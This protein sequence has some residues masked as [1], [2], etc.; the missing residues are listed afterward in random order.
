MVNKQCP[1]CGKTISDTDIF[2]K[3]CGFPLLEKD[4]FQDPTQENISNELPKN[5][6][7][8]IGIPDNTTSL[9]KCPE[10]GQEI[11][12][13]AD[14]C[15]YCGYPLHDLKNAKHVWHCANCGQMT[16]SSPCSHCG[17][18]S[19]GAQE[20]AFVLSENKT[21]DSI[22]TNKDEKTDHRRRKK[23]LL[24]T[25]IF[26]I[27][28]VLILSVLSITVV[29]PSVQ[30]YHAKELLQNK[31]YAAAFAAFE[32]LGNYKDAEKLAQEA[33]TN[34]FYTL[35]VE[36][37]I[38]A[39][40]GNSDSYVEFGGRNW[41][42]LAIE[43]NKALLLSVNAVANMPYHKSSADVTWES[44][45]LRKYLNED[46]YKTFSDEERAMIVPVE[47]ENPDNDS[48]GT[49]G[50]ATTTD[51]IFLLSS[52]EAEAY[53]GK[54]KSSGENSWWLRSPGRTNGHAACVRKYGDLSKKGFEVTRSENG[55]RPALWI[56]I[57]STENADKIMDQIGLSVKDGKPMIHMGGYDWRILDISQNRLFVVSDEIV[58]MKM[59]PV[60][61][62]V[63]NE[64]DAYSCSGISEYLNEEF[65]QN[66][67]DEEKAKI[68]LQNDFG[69]IF[70]LSSEEVDKY[71]GDDSEYDKPNLSYEDLYIDQDDLIRDS[72]QKGKIAKYKGKATAW[73]LRD[74][75]SD[76][77]YVVSDEGVTYRR[78][79]EEY[80]GIRPA[81][82]V[83][84]INTEYSERSVSINQDV[85]AD[86][87]LTYK[88]LSEKYGQATESDGLYGGIYFKFEKSPGIYFFKGKDGNLNTI[89]FIDEN[90]QVKPEIV[91]D[92]VCWNVRVN[93]KELFTGLQGLKSISDIEEEIGVSIEIWENADTLGYDGNFS[94]QGFGISLELDDHS[95]YI[96]ENSA[97]RFRRQN[98]DSSAPSE[99]DDPSTE[100]V[101]MPFFND[102]LLADI[103][104]TYANISAKYIDP[105]SLDGF[106]GDLYA[107]ISGRQYRFVPG[108]GNGSAYSGD[109]DNIVPNDDAVC[110][111]IDAAARDLFFEFSEGMSASDLESH[112]ISAATVSSRPAAAAGEIEGNFCRFE[113]GNC[114]VYIL[115]DENSEAFFSNSQ[116]FIGLR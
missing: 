47:N 32:K 72:I 6:E 23:G 113:Y 112:G 104:Q 28:L 111:S 1:E 48:Y 3:N 108:N 82:W 95:N 56:R 73:W 102:S 93:A 60:V 41:K 8:G 13:K 89:D 24:L 54:Y 50:G 74:V 101:E 76:G 37:I 17:K 115:L 11:S 27:V 75:G 78:W 33:Q 106:E 16:D 68:S 43:E 22:I 40:I 109:F 34:V 58:Q 45:D 103:G 69:K 57:S 15:I 86:I 99:S 7:N 90:G 71:F 2:C 63:W 35:S 91:S 44:C 87:G 53:E 9:I 49:D 19:T 94:Y 100:P 30:Y 77:A 29:M 62:P 39:N 96:T 21:S 61:I 38:S 107:V 65:T 85:F 18:S 20:E 114:E 52:Q 84:L 10:C 81:M 66:F 59:Y 46:Y 98:G 88:E 42:I 67:S 97:V 12:D 70:L 51:K 25:V 105:T 116:I 26:G 79:D 83:E 31:E 5:S 92:I 14:A 64:L 4:A 80:A 55:V 110:V 36:E